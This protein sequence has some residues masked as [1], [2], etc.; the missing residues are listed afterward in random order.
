MDKTWDFTSK[1]TTT[2]VLITWTEMQT[3]YLPAP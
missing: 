1:F 3:Q 2:D